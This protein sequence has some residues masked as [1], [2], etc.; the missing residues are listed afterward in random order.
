[1]LQEGARSQH[2]G[3][4][5]EAIVL[6]TERVLGRLLMA[7]GPIAGEPRAA[8]ANVNASQVV[9]AAVSIPVKGSIKFWNKPTPS[10]GRGIVICAVMRSLR[11]VRLV[12]LDFLVRY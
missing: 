11:E 6:Y 7:L 12:M 1:M 5:Q 3:W 8:F 10:K 9:R 2:T 4:R